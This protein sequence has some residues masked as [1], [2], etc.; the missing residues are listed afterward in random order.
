MTHFL[1]E[2]TD[3]HMIEE[4]GS[5]PEKNLVEGALLV[6]PEQSIIDSGGGNNADL[7]APGIHQDEGGSLELN[8]DVMIERLQEQANMVSFM[9]GRREVV[10][11]A[12]DFGG[13]E[14]YYALHHIFIR[15]TAVF[16]VVF[17]LSDALSAPDLVARHLIHWVNS[18]HTYSGGRY[19]RNAEELDIDNMGENILLVGTHKDVIPADQLEQ[20][21]KAIDDQLYGIFKGLD[22]YCHLRFPGEKNTGSRIFFAVSNKQGDNDP[23]VAELRDT[24]IDV[25]D[26][27]NFIHVPRPLRWIRTNDA[28]RVWA[29]KPGSAPYGLPGEI[30]TYSEAHQAANLMMRRISSTDTTRYDVCDAELRLMLRFLHD[31]GEVVYIEDLVPE[32]EQSDNLIVLSYAWLV[33]MMKAVLIR[34]D[35]KRDT[36]MPP[37]YKRQRPHKNQSDWSQMWEDLWSI[38]KLHGDLLQFRLWDEVPEAASNVVLRLFDRLD[39]MCAMPDDDP[40]DQVSYLIPSIALY[41]NTNRQGLVQERLGSNPPALSGALIAFLTFSGFLPEGLLSRLL[42][43]GVR[44]RVWKIIKVSYQRATV[45]LK[46]PRT[47]ASLSIQLVAEPALSRIGC[48]RYSQAAEKATL[49]HDSAEAALVTFGVLLNTCKTWYAPAIIALKVGCNEDPDHLFD[50]HKEVLPGMVKDRSRKERLATLIARNGVEVSRKQFL[51]WVRAQKLLSQSGKGLCQVE[52]PTY[53]VFDL[54]E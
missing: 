25:I 37:E 42:V 52:C 11:S 16:L 45:V 24:I 23:E 28:F 22:C 47:G 48:Y 38:G 44:V 43:Q 34:N 36:K 40:T 20:S 26:S 5:G 19:T 53:D 54:S 50:V 29:R 13:Q 27:M 2:V 41:Y 6:P 10:I 33:R 14:L 39:L 1:S 30:M 35:A 51:P 21:L 8:D 31:I 7:I 46:L 49:L 32:E 12:W 3:A 4:F 18:I 17:S 9:P 15:T